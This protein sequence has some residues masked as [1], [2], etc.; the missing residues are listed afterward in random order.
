MKCIWGLIKNPSG[1]EEDVV[2]EL[3]A[4]KWIKIYKETR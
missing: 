4:G 2:Y 3:R 1:L